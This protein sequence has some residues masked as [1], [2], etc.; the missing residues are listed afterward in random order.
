MELLSLDA[1]RN[2]VKEAV[3][4][5]NSLTLAQE[6]SIDHKADV[7]KML[8]SSF[9]EKAHLCNAIMD[10]PEYRAK[11]L[12]LFR[13][14]LPLDEMKVGPDTTLGLGNKYW[15]ETALEYL[16]QELRNFPLEGQDF[17]ET[18]L[19]CAP[20]RTRHGALNVLQAWISAKGIPLSQ[21][22]PDFQKLLMRLSEVEIKDEIKERM[23][24][25]I[26]ENI[27][28]EDN[29]GDN[30]DDGQGRE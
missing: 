13:Q 3:S 10:D 9:E 26:A 8:E 29:L 18:G 23:E 16:M 12:E 1:C 11:V 4:K 14:R 7:F 5:G 30:D 28:F 24:R 15:K 27:S 6:L 17:I 20:V 22:L 21:L 2:V 25:L 19:Q